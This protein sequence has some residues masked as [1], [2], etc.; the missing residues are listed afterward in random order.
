MNSKNTWDNRPIIGVIGANRANEDLLETAYDLGRELARRGAILVC[1]GLG[2]VME[3]ACRGAKELGGLTLG[4]LPGR[5]AGQA[6]RYVDLPIVTGLGEA[7]NFVLVLTA[8]ALIAC[9]GGPG[10]LSEIAFA[11]QNEKILAGIRTWTIVDGTG[12]EGFFPVFQDPADA[13]SSVLGR[14]GGA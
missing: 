13:V 6:N 3:A 9:G 14:L 7:R 11:L 2:G 12:K 1:G 8:Q 4:I 5:E 10:T